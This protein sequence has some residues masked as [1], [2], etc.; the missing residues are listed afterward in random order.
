VIEIIINKPERR[1]ALARTKR[2]TV[3]QFNDIIVQNYDVGLHSRRHPMTRTYL[4]GETRSLFLCVGLFSC[5][6]VSFHVCGTA[7]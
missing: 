7:L 1:R 3:S 4:K 2:Q 5:V 6:W